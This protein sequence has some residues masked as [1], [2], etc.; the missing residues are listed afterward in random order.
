MPDDNIAR[1]K[2]PP[3]KGQF[4]PGQSGNPRGRPK[5][6]RNIRTYVHE[7]LGAKIPVIEGG[8]TRHI[9]RAEA[10]AIQLVNLAAKGDPKGLAAILSLTREFD[11]AIGQPRPGALTHIADIEVMQDI[12]ARI[13][14]GD[15]LPSVDAGS[16]PSANEFVSSSEPLESPSE[17]EPE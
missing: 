4:Q 5:G 10:I 9:P 2:R 1:H 15:P 16:D 17:Q 13:R 11:E 3:R 7:L 12:I 8:K 14:A 6:S